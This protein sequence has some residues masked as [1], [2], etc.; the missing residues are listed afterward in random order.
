MNKTELIAAVAEKAEISKKDA[1]KAI[2]AFTEA[3]S[4]EL[5]KGGKIQLVGFGTFEVS[6]RAAREGRAGGVGRG[7][8]DA[9][10]ETGSNGEVVV[11]AVLEAG[12][13]ELELGDAARGTSVA[14]LPTTRPAHRPHRRAFPLWPRR[15]HLPHLP[16]PQLSATPSYRWHPVLCAHR[17]L[18]PFVHDLQLHRRRAAVAP[19]R[20]HHRYY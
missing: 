5:V 12:E 19:R 18:L 6:E 16:R 14:R 3:V 13:S 10:V 4:E 7:D 9:G 2:K 20:R 1:E 11:V 17:L 8:G 15:P